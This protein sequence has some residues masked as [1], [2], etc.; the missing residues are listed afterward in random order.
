MGI[1]EDMRKY[2]NYGMPDLKM[3]IAV[4]LKELEMMR[5]QY[6]QVSKERN[7]LFEQKSNM[8]LPDVVIPQQ[9]KPQG[10]PQG[11]PRLQV[12]PQGQPRVSPVSTGQPRPMPSG[13]PMQ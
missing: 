4:L 6:A 5:I 7:L 10:Q 2:D 11:Q 12:M 9:L 1:I 8:K 13:M 3:E